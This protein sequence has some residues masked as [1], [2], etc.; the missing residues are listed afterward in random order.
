M[1]STSTIQRISYLILVATITM[2]FAMSGVIKFTNN[3]EIINNFSKWN[4]LDYKIWIGA[5]ECL[6]VIVYLLP[7]TNLLGALVFTG[8]MIGA[9]YTH[10]IHQQPFYFQI[11]IILV[12][13]V[14]FLLVKPKKQLK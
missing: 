5:I 11:A 13:W 1:N 2:I 6:L 3:E 7:K 14:N 10:F 12:I 8:V 9:S 4:L